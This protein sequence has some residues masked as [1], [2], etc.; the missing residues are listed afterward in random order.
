MVQGDVI[1]IDESVQH[2]RE[3]GCQA[4]FAAVFEGVQQAAHGLIVKAGRPSGVIG[5]GPCGTRRTNT[6]GGEYL[7]TARAKPA[8][9]RGIER[10]GGTA[11]IAQLFLP[12]A[13]KTAS[14]AKRAWR[15]VVQKGPAQ[16]AMVR[17]N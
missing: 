6:I 14:L 8:E 7:Q 9:R 5:G 1:G 15:A 2:L 4:G 17:K 10:D 12:A 13:V 16:R 11:G 3:S